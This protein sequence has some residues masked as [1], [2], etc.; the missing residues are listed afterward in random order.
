MVVSTRPSL[1]LAA[2]Q[3]GPT[4]PVAVVGQDHGHFDGRF[5]NPRLTAVL[6][7]AVPRLDAFAV[8]TEADAA[9]YRARFTGAATP[10]PASCRT[11][12]RGRSPTSRLP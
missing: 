12:C 2:L 1:H 9:D 8:L 5:G 7:W 4:R 11:R 3:L 10:H 6:D